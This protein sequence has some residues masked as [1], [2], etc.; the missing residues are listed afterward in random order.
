MTVTT[1]VPN[2]HTNRILT[3]RLVQRV[4]K[5]AGDG[6]RTVRLLGLRLIT[7]TQRRNLY[8]TT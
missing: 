1:I 5:S 3:F 8:T 6:V 4:A 2:G 7:R